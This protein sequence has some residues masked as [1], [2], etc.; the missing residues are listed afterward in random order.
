MI[1]VRVSCRYDFIPVPT[2]SSVF[3]YMM[4]DRY[5]SYRYEFTP[6][7]VPVR[8]VRTGMRFD[9]ILYRYHVK[10]VRGFVPIRDEWLS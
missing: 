3:V 5:E 1:P 9:H 8:N 6:V 2:C 10:E 7:L 4:S